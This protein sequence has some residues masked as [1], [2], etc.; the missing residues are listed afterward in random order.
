[1]DRRAGAGAGT[2]RTR[3]RRRCPPTW[4][5]KHDVPPAQLAPHVDRLVR[6][7]QARTPAPLR[8]ALQRGQRADR[9]QPS[10]ARTAR[11]SRSGPAASPTS[12]ESAAI[13]M[14]SAARISRPA[15]P[16]PARA[17]QAAAAAARSWPARRRPAGP[18]RASVRPLTGV[19][20]NSPK[21]PQPMSGL[22]GPQLD[23]GAGGHDEQQR[24]PDPHR[25]RGPAVAERARRSRSARRRSRTPPRRS[26]SRPARRRLQREQG[27]R[28]EP[29]VDRADAAAPGR[30][31]RRSR[32]AACAAS[33]GICTCPDRSTVSMSAADRH[34]RVEAAR[35][36]ARRRARRSW[37]GSGR[38]PAR[39]ARSRRRRTGR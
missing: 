12:G 8:A 31:W 11:S 19:R 18:T 15:G 9:G 39:A 7:D 32:R 27:G 2:P 13:T 1:M 6:G 21:Q 28:A 34:R 35:A 16:P 30:T 33:S 3:A 5:G 17:R 24:G 23:Q 37:P 22:A 20:L 4:A 26:P 10:A 38:R 25:V 29:G 14:S 36:R